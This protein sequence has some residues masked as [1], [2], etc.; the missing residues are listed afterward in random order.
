MS[1]Q[2]STM[3]VDWSLIARLNG[4]ICYALIFE[5][6]AFL[7]GMT[8]P[9]TDEVVINSV[10]TLYFARELCRYSIL[11][12][13]NWRFKIMHYVQNLSVLSKLCQLIGKLNI[14][15]PQ[16]TEYNHSTF[17]VVF[18]ERTTKCLNHDCKLTVN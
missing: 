13:V 1:I 12:I 6:T 15:M 17:Q 5:H 16:M 7:L 9:I 8:K 14:T 11:I 4:S 3:G 2:P 18:T 10:G